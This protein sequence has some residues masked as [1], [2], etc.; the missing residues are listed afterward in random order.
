M[1]VEVKVIPAE[2]TDGQPHWYS[3]LITNDEGGS[4]QLGFEPTPEALEERWG[5]ER[6]VF[7]EEWS[8]PLTDEDHA[9]AKRR[10]EYL[11]R[12]AR[13]RADGCQGT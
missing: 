9:R 8:K 10:E 3:F 13:R 2:R 12:N 1:S 4:M 6:D 5:F 11:A 7:V